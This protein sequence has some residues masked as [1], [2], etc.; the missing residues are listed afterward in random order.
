MSWEGRAKAWETAEEE[1][2]AGRGTPGLKAEAMMR[3]REAPAVEAAG[4]GRA[5]MGEAAGMVAR[6]SWAMAGMADAE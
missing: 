5:T 4:E 2:A 3:A 1:L 6:G